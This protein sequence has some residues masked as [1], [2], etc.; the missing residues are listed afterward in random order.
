MGIFDFFKK[1]E[2]SATKTTFE[3]SPKEEFEENEAKMMNESSKEIL[4]IE[5]I[6]D[7]SA[8]HGDNFGALL[9][10]GFLNSSDGAQFI[11]EMIALAMVQP[12]LSQN[13]VFSIHQVDFTQAGGNNSAVKLK[14]I[15]ANQQIITAY[16]YLSTQYNL[17]FKTKQI[18]EWSN[19]A[20][21]EAE[22][23]GGGRD[24]F[25]FGFF[26]TDYAQKRTIYTSQAEIN[27]RIS[28]FALV[29]AQSDLTEI[30]G[31]PVSP[32]FAS[33]MPNNDIPR[34]TYYDFIGTVN[35]AA[36]CSLNADLH[37]YHLNV[38]LIHMDGQPDFF[39]VDMFVN[40]E[41]MRFEH[42]EAGMKVTGMLWFQGEIV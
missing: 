30:N 13:P 40:K 22:I 6:S 7:D 23:K 10:F 29:L 28:A 34:V 2:T 20:G 42:L 8:S 37:G 1:K 41:N 25:G 36:A 16:P 15:Q 9:G 12:P 4:E 38:K 31:T 26:A 33:Y 11:N 14:T 27:V 35:H 24:T 18:I 32:D 5:V 21:L 19:A 3:T 17:P 39:T